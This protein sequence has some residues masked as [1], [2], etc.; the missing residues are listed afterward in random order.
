MSARPGGPGPVSAR[1]THAPPGY[2]CPFCRIAGTL[3]SPAPEAAVVLVD[4]NVFALVPTHHYAGVRGNCLVVPRAHHENVFDIPDSLGSEF[5][6][7]TRRLAQAM[8]TVFR[9]EGI[10][11]RQHNGPA[12]NQD[13]WHY[14]LHVFPRYTGDGLREGRKARYAAGERIEL[15]AR[16]RAALR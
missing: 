4:A 10:S 15:A 12:G 13:V 11:T 6:R 14:H 8:R 3:P 2:E 9:C 7:A 1:M 5:F 16:L